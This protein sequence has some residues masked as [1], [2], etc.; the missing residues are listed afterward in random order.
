MP[1]IYHSNPWHPWKNDFAWA[2]I[3]LWHLEVYDYPPVL[4]GIR[5]KPERL[6]IMQRFQIGEQRDRG[7][8]IGIN[9][10][11]PKKNWKC[12]LQ[13]LSR[14]VG[15]LFKYPWNLILIG[16]KDCDVDQFD[17]PVPLKW[18]LMKPEGL[19][20]VGFPLKEWTD[21]ELW[22]FI[23][24]YHVPVQH[25]TRYSG[26]EEIE[27]KAFNNDYMEACTACIDPRNSEEVWCPLYNKTIANVSDKIT[28]F[29]GKPDYI[30]VKE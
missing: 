23:E 22:E 30:G 7:I 6:E 4:T 19:P 1:V 3:K 26:R 16:H 25:G 2:M 10:E 17:G 15:A 9:I 27:Y 28:K 14:P 11:P 13:M 29:E 24:H 12:G 18:D 8:H 20:T 21:E 5:V